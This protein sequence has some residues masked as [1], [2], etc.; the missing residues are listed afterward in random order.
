MTLSGYSADSQSKAADPQTEL[1]L[2]TLTNGHAPS[3][4]EQVALVRTLRKEAADY[5]RHHS[6]FSTVASPIRVLARMVREVENAGVKV[7]L[8]QQVLERKVA[9]REIGDGDE[10]L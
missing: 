3:E 9:H 7:G 4:E 1:E 2:S 6:N 5:Y 10:S 8:A